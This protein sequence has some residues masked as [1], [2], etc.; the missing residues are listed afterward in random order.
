M[1]SGGK[2]ESDHMVPFRLLKGSFYLIP[3]KTGSHQRIFFLINLFG[4]ASLSCNMR[5]LSGSMWDLVP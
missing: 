3:L 1:M 5:V 4:C 2:K